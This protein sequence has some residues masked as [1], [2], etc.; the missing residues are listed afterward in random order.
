MKIV[1]DQNKIEHDDD[2]LDEYD[3]TKMS[4]GVRGKYYKSYRAS[5]IVKI[6]KTDGN[7]KHKVFVHENPNT[8][9]QR[10]EGHK[11]KS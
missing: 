2:M 8:K 6:Q 5:H 10:H 4:G 3:F 9:S 11:K 1:S 7:A